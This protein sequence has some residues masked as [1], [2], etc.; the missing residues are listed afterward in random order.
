MKIRTL[1]LAVTAA[2]AANSAF[3]LT[4]AEITTARNAATLHE[5]W[6]SGASATT[7][8][9]FEGFKADCTD[10]V[11]I[12]TSDATGTVPG[13]AGDF[14]AYA[15]TTATLGKT[16]M[17]HTVAGGSFNAFAPHVVGTQLNRVKRPD[18][19]PACV[20]NGG[21]PLVYNSCTN[22]NPVATP[23]SSV[24]LP[25]GGVS[26]VD[27]PLFQDLFVTAPSSVG[28]E[29][30]AN[31][32]QVFGVAVSTNLYRAMQTAQG[33][34]TATCTDDT[35]N[36]VGKVYTQVGS[37]DFRDPACMP[38]ISK[39]QYTSIAASGGGLQTD[40]QF[41]L[42]AAGANKAVNL[43]RRV[44]TSGT[45]AS[46]NAHFLRNPCNR[47]A[48]TGGELAPIDAL[49]ST[50]ASATAASGILVTESSGTSDVK[51]CLNKANDN[52][53]PYFAIG[54]VSAENNPFGESLADRDDYRFIKLDSVSP[55]NVGDD[56]ARQ[57]AINGNYDFTM[58]LS[59]YTANTASVDGG[60]MINTVVTKMGTVGGAD[61]RGLY[62]SPYG[63]ADH[64]TNPTI[65]GK[66]T[67]GGNNCQPMNM[68]F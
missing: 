39:A 47:G 48:A 28:G 15:C 44:P 65:V 27:S 30:S 20:V 43:C 63:G 62:I 5:V 33:L 19:N 34:A 59:A 55:E 46:S 42:G 2:L 66:G 54:V 17:Y 41:L 25:D 45:Q 18:S 10:A 6:M 53:T 52:A 32:F 56:K 35:Y 67:R 57:N 29:V 23:D 21:N 50:A 36:P 13:S 16:V 14:L 26:D 9:T 7:R 4:P 11:H 8:N 37:H 51:K 22:I 60:A 31:V 64:T 3:A 40:W 61:L 49:G 1:A 58:E 12:Y 68:Y 38:N 24:A